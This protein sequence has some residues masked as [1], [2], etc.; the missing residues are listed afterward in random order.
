[1]I[2]RSD[3]SSILSFIHSLDIEAKL[4]SGKFLDLIILK[5]HFNKICLRDFKFFK[6]SIIKRF[7]Y[8]FVTFK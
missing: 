5:Y 7:N 1:M 3:I 6:T 8:N 2:T 4:Y